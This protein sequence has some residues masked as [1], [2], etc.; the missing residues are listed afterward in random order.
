MK[1]MAQIYIILL[2]NI[3]KYYITLFSQPGNVDLM[4]LKLL[5]GCPNS[6]IVVKGKLSYILLFRPGNHNLKILRFA[7]IVET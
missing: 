5:S 7:I 2:Y 1:W 3:K 4:I 6:N